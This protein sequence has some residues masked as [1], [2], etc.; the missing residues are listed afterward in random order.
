M[1]KS[2]HTQDHN[3]PFLW[4]YENEKV[5]VDNP[6]YDETLELVSNSRNVPAR[7]GGGTG[8]PQQAH[9]DQL[10]KIVQA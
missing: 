3:K 10:V 9:H 7:G 6:G 4:L 2:Y 8:Q 5:V 1:I